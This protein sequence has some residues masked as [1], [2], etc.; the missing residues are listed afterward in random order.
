MKTFL[1]LR[2]WQISAALIALSFAES[3][4]AQPPANDPPVKPTVTGK[5]VGNGKNAAI[6]FVLVEEREPFSDKEAIKLIFTE[7]NPATAKKPSW[8]A[9]FGKL[10][11][12]LVLSVHHDGGIFGCEVSHSAHSKRG[13]SSVGEIKMAEFKI[14]PGFTS[15]CETT[16][17]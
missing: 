5:F 1:F 14:W 2:F 8:D 12:A 6:Q 13:F 15:H 11:S 17:M 16:P 9:G 3:A 7:K 10:G 4:T